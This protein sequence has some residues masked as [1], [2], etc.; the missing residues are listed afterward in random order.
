MTGRGLHAE[1]EV[2]RAQG[3][4]GERRP[5]TCIGSRGLR[6]A[7]VRPSGYCLRKATLL[8]PEPMVE[9][10]DGAGKRQI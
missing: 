10:R 9:Q 8:A 6:P 7:S 4:P 1:V 5:L 2:N 3:S